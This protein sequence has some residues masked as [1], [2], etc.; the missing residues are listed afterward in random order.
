MILFEN[1][2]IISFWWVLFL[3]KIGRHVTGPQ[4]SGRSILPTRMP[5]LKRC[6]TSIILHLLYYKTLAH[7]W[8]V[9][10]DIDVLRNGTSYHDM[11]Y[12]TRFSMN[13]R[14]FFANWIIIWVITAL[15]T[16]YQSLTLFLSIKKSYGCSFPYFTMGIE[17]LISPTNWFP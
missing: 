13:S 12:T 6:P 1:V 5:R 9:T 4:K 16:L 14:L 17:K 10:L 3:V 11:L 8:H 15:A 2:E 7:F